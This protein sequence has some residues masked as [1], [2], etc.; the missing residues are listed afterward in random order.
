MSV[1]HVVLRTW[2]WKVPWAQC[3]HTDACRTSCHVPVPQPHYVQVPVDVPQPYE[4]PVEQL[5]HS[6]R[7]VPVPVMQQQFM[8]Q[9]MMQQPMYQQPMY[10]QPMT[11]GALPM[12]FDGSGHQPYVRALYTRRAHHCVAPSLANQKAPFLLGAL[13]AAHLLE[14]SS[15]QPIRKPD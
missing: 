6:V 2:A 15:R 4:V 13:V 1:L 5:V 11:Y 9:P 14:R 10:Q 3:L 12:D 8:Q 7:D